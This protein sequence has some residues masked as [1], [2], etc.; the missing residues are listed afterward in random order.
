MFADNLKRYKSE[1]KVIRNQGVQEF[2]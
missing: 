2:C 1:I